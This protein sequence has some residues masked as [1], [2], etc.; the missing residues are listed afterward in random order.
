MESESDVV[1]L[2]TCTE[3]EKSG[4]EKTRYS[5]DAKRPTRVTPVCDIRRETMACPESGDLPSNNISHRMWQT[6]RERRCLSVVVKGMME[7]SM[8]DRSRR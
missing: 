2:Q 7:N 8:S 4:G 5:A 6:S 1:G 3:Y